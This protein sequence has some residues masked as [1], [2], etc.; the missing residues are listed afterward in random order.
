[1]EWEMKTE[2]RWIFPNLVCLCNSQLNMFGRV[3]LMFMDQL[4]TFLGLSVLIMVDLPELSRP[5]IIIFDFFFPKEP[6]I[7]NL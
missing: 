7:I 6:P 3:I 1:M 2:I 4:L 5:T